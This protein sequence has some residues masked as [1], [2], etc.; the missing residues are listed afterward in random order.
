ME[1][2]FETADLFSA[3]VF[4]LVFYTLDEVVP[5]LDPPDDVV[6]LLDPI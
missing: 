2:D 4:T 3:I 6:H 1:L 5:I